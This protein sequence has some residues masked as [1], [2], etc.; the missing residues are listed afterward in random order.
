MNLR[1]RRDICLTGSACDGIPTFSCPREL[2]QH[3]GW[4]SVELVQAGAL[5]S[6]DEQDGAIRKG[7]ESGIDSAILQGPSAV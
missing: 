1:A 2:D 5:E 7:D 4:D 3:S 6:T